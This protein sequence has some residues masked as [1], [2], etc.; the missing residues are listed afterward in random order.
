[1]LLVVFVLVFVAVLYGIY[2]LIQQER[3]SELPQR[4]YP[5]DYEALMKFVEKADDAYILTHATLDIMY[6]SKFASG[7]ACNELIEFLYRNP[8]KMF[9]SR[10]HRRRSWDVLA[11]GERYV[12]LKKS[13]SHRQ[14]KVKRGMRIKLGDDMIEYWEIAVTS[15]G[16]EVQAVNSDSELEKEVY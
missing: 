10:K 4:D 7:K 2:F 11:H 15:S 6:F 8:P 9:G 12:V 16:F 13:I 14:V 5:F 3:K 1:M